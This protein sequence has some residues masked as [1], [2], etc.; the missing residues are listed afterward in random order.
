MF[1]AHRGPVH[2]KQSEG[3]GAYTAVRRPHHPPW[4]T[5]GSRPPF[6]QVKNLSGHGKAESVSRGWNTAAPSEAPSPVERE[7]VRSRVRRAGVGTGSRS[8]PLVPQPPPR[9]LAAG[10]AAGSCV[11]THACAGT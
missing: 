3:L 6:L 4:P 7:G 5:V 2:P 1:C 10:T 11:C 8:W 9:V